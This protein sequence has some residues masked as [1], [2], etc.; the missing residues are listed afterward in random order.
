MPP[1]TRSKRFDLSLNDVVENDREPKKPRKWLQSGEISYFSSKACMERYHSRFIYGETVPGRSIDLGFFNQEGFQLGKWFKHMNW[2]SFI[3]IKEKFYPELVRHFYANLSFDADKAQINSFVKGK[4]IRLNQKSLKKIIG[5]PNFGTEICENDY[6]W[7]ENDVGISRVEAFKMLLE[8]PDSSVVSSKVDACHLKLEMRLLHLMVVH[9]ILPRKRSLNCVSDMDLLVMWHILNGMDFN[10]PFVLLSHMVACS[11]KKNAYLPYGMML[12]LIFKHFKV[13]L[14]E[15]ECKELKS[16]DIYSEVTL[17]KM[18]YVKSEKG[19]FLKKDK[20]VAH[21]ILS[22]ENLNV[23]EIQDS[24]ATQLSLAIS[25]PANSLPDPNPASSAPPSPNVVFSAEEGR[26]PDKARQPSV[27]Q[28]VFLLVIAMQ[29]DMRT[30][31]MGSKLDDLQSKIGNLR[32]LITQLGIKRQERTIAD[33]FLLLEV[34][35]ANMRTLRS[36]MDNFGN[37]IDHWQSQLNEFLRQSQGMEQ[38]D[39][40]CIELMVAETIT[41]QGRNRGIIHDFETIRSEIQ[42]VWDC[43]S[44]NM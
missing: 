12:T 10:L 20:A 41:F 40:E 7:V 27:V 19:W 25:A 4:E 18:G 28:G 35:M 22:Q 21:P 2:V 13:S 39:R 6:K 15:E 5:I 36:K 23:S 42:D 8:N 9:I 1:E 34:I 24:P 17:R 37:K 33:I 38:F 44:S 31:T 3:L 14:E 16:S 43:L 29:E 11:E 32:S 26:A 30:M